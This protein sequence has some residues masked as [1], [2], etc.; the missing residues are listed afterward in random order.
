MKV[1]ITGHT[2]GIGKAISDLYESKGH[3]IVG[4][5][6][7]NGYDIS[8]PEK[9]KSIVDQSEDCEIFFNNAHCDTANFSQTELLFELWER[10]QGKNKKIVNISSAITMRWQHDA[11]ILQ[12]RTAKIGL[13]D[14]CNFLWN[15]SPW[16]AIVIAGPCVTDTDRVLYHPATNKVNPMDFAELIYYNIHQTNFRVQKIQLAVNPTTFPH[17]ATT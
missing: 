10:W 2:K 3:T 1:A 13:E 17:T 9:R 14:A 4:F 6:R 12:Y 11:R 15:K 8:D 7:S 5:S 16:P